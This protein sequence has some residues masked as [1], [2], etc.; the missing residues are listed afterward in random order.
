M[1]I[2]KFLGLSGCCSRADA[3]RAIRARGV[4]VNGVA[5]SS[6]DTKINPN[7][8]LVTYFGR[9]VVYREYNYILLNK[10]DG[11]V[12]ATEDTRE[13]TVID[14]LPDGVRNDRMFPC[15]RLDKNT[16]GLMLITDDGNLAHELLSPRSHVSKRYRFCCEM[17]MS[18]E[19]S[20]MF[21]NGLVLDDGYETL[22]AKI[23]LDEGG[24]SGIITLTEGK[25]HQIKRM[26]AALG[27]K[28]TYLERIT[29]GPLSLDGTLGR[30]EWRYLT[31]EEIEK[32]KNHKSNLLNNGE[33]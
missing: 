13:K 6:A 21:E 28:I 31:D 16:L 15:G 19:E 33:N 30:G 9:M 14:L 25:Y 27:N 10:P 8:D 7:T 17:P 22:P 4:A 26:L 29:F 11:V 20:L 24:V 3:K 32:L 12:S 5:V 18:R 2:D 23:E 1:R